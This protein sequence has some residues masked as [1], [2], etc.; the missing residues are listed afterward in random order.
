MVG[1]SWFSVGGFI[2][3][4]VTL[5]LAIRGA[6]RALDHAETVADRASL[7]L[8][9]SLAATISSAVVV[10]AVGSSALFHHGEVCVQGPPGVN[11]IA[12]C[13][14]CRVA[15]WGMYLGIF[16]QIVSFIVWP[17]WRR[18]L[19]VQLSRGLHVAVLW[20]SMLSTYL[21]CGD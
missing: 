14:A 3:A 9:I 21:F 8:W 13:S 18:S 16:L 6:P 4:I 10:C 7:G 2:A 12:L 17:I 1:V 15:A 11:D 19:E 20:C 5:G